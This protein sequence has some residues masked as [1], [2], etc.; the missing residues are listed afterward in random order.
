MDYADIHNHLVPGVDDGSRNEEM[1]VRLLHQAAAEGITLMIATPHNYPGHSEQKIPLVKERFERLQE[2][3]NIETPQI[4][5]YLG[6]EVFYRDRIADDLEEGLAL[7][8]ADT[9]YVLTEFHPAES[10]ENVFKGLRRLTEGGWRPVIAHVERIEVFNGDTAALQNL[11]DMGALLQVNT[12]T[13][14]GGFFDRRSKFWRTMA[15][16]GLISFLGSD[17]HHPE[18]RPVMMKAAI[19]KLSK[20]MTADR[21]ARLAWENAAALVAGERVQ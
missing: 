16:Q 19:T 18:R 9:R 4:R 14:T 2:L 10:R 7:P 17:A 13:M 20:N 15:A 21:L 8:L 6:N 12:H 1:S 3:A 5:L 11:R